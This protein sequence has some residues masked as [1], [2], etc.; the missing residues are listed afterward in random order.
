MINRRNS[1][2]NDSTSSLGSNGQQWTYLHEEDVK[3]S[4][5]KFKYAYLE[6]L[7]KLIKFDKQK[8]FRFP[9]DTK[10]V[11]DYT[12]YIKTPMDFETM[13]A[14][15]EENKYKDDIRV[16]EA[17]IWL[18]INNCKTY[19][20]RDTIF[21]E[22]AVKLEDFYLK[23]KHILERKLGTIINLINRKY[24]STAKSRQKQLLSGSMSPS[25]SGMVPYPSAGDNPPPTRPT[26]PR[27][28]PIKLETESERLEFIQSRLEPV[29]RRKRKLDQKRMGNGLLNSTMN[30]VQIALSVS[31][32]TNETFGKLMAN[33]NGLPR[34]L[35]SLDVAQHQLLVNPHSRNMFGPNSIARL[36]RIINSFEWKRSFD[37]PISMGKNTLYRKI[38][39]L[40]GRYKRE[41][42]K[43]S[44]ESFIGEENLELMN[45]L[46]PNLSDILGDLCIPHQMLSNTTEFKN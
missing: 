1:S 36:R 33:F 45:E 13:L 14:K 8:I 43:K 24:L 18:I 23:I 28:G 37:F 44:V 3:D 25:E 15:N 20:S 6:T 17:D 39:L 16:F 19:N 12:N 41:T 7:N 34:L 5:I 38:Q 22:A 9:V 46:F 40:M 4:L 26:Y 42:Y 21:Y 29:K 27:T 10:L 35:N 31:G 11:P 2:S 30:T 32:L